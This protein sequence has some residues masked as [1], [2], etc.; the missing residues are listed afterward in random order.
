MRQYRA[1]ETWRGIVWVD[2]DD[3]VDEINEENNKRTF[4]FK[5]ITGTIL[6]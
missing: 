3:L 2:K 1:A 6:D 4:S 5:V